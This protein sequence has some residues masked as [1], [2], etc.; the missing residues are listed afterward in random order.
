MSID[1]AAAKVRKLNSEL[2]QFDSQPADKMV[3]QANT[4]VAQCAQNVEALKQEVATLREQQVSA[5]SEVDKT[6]TLFIESQAKFKQMKPVTDADVGEFDS[7]VDELLA[8][9]E[10]SDESSIPDC[11]TA[12]ANLK[13]N[14][15]AVDD[16][17]TQ[18]KII[19]SKLQDLSLNNRISKLEE[20]LRPAIDALDIEAEND[21]ANSVAEHVIDR[22]IDRAQSEIQVVETQ[23]E[24]VDQQSGSDLQ[25]AG[26]QVRD[27]KQ[28]VEDLESKRDDALQ[29]KEKASK[30][31]KELN[32]VAERQRNELERL[33]NSANPNASIHS[34]KTTFNNTLQEW[35]SFF[36]SHDERER[37]QI[38]WCEFDSS[39][40]CNEDPTEPSLQNERVDAPIA[41]QLEQLQEVIDRAGHELDGTRQDLKTATKERDT[42]HGQLKQT[43]GASI[44]EE[45]EREQE[46]L[47]Q[48]QQRAE[49]L[50]QEYKAARQLFELLQEADA[51]NSSHLGRQL[52]QPV[53]QAFL[54]LT[55]NRYSDL[56]LSPEMSLENIAARGAAR[57]TEEL[58]VGT[59]D[60]LATL[61]RLT[62]AAQ[63]RTSVIMDDQLAHSDDQRMSWFRDRFLQST[64]EQSHQ[65]I[66]ITCRPEDYQSRHMTDCN[67]KMID[68]TQIMS[69]N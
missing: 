34:A 40:F 37:H 7:H 22:V 52:A 57:E 33:V 16:L 30:T 5:Q 48:L 36:E 19:E 64:I 18:C 27:A 46:A 55:Q 47:Q 44:A 39:P 13:T 26:N 69:N 3:A 31:Y 4:E 35:S 62:L 45:L 8:E 67:S 29:A 61:I 38:A 59:R 24:S 6:H 51:R 25:D 53:Q 32:S 23:I 56:T 11:Q 21:V 42:T 58:S 49:D 41:L 12:A 60:Q 28:L 50:E 66:V 9:L 14:E 17:E 43:G 68:L 15:E 10:L 54:E 1:Q 20:S 2:Q 65:I 63:L